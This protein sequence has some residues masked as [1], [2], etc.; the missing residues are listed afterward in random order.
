M[1][2]FHKR[3]MLNRHKRSEKPTRQKGGNPFRCWD[4]TAE[5]NYSEHLLKRERDGEI[6]ELEFGKVYHLDS[7]ISWRSDASYFDIAEGRSITVDVKGVLDVRFGLV[8][9]MWR[10]HGPN[11]LHI[12]KRPGIGGEFKVT[13]A[14]MPLI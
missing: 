4:S 1:K 6:K 8:M 10:F 11:V 9:R 13:K 3:D 7:G 12:V 2:S 5:K 14:I